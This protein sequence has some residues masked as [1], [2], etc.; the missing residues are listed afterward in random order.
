[1]ATEPDLQVRRLLF[2]YDLFPYQFSQHGS[3]MKIETVIGN[4][5]LKQKK[6]TRNQINHLLTAYKLAGKLA[7][8]ALSPLPSK[9]GDLVI[10]GDGDSGYYLLPW[11]EETVPESDLLTRYTRLFLKA[12]QMH[13]QTLR[14]DD[15][16]DQL[17]QSMVQLLTGRQNIWERF[18]QEAEYHVYPSPFEQLVLSSAGGYLTNLQNALLYFQGTQKEVEEGT[19]NAAKKG[20]RRALCHGRLN[21][22]HIVIE[23]EKCYLINF[24]ECSYGIFIIEAAS[25]FE[26]ASAVLSKPHLPWKA[27]ISSYLA[28][29]PL[30]DNETTFLFHYLM[31]P[32]API[33]LLEKYR[34]QHDQ[35]EFWFTQHWITLQ[36][37]QSEMI[38]AFQGYYEEK[39]KQSNHQEEQ[40]SD[41]S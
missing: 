38:R 13:Q 29:C 34:L 20:M 37:A 31:C 23:N 35:S 3:V 24:E 7:I 25:L 4:F 21:P 26:Q 40:T 2:Q 18:V 17:Y 11:F 33:N 15:N 27:W 5:A 6:I 1:M 10:Q 12:G 14:G 41:D 36:R 28:A 39:Q 32:L 30:T 9:Y 19:E 8:D 22:L 16:P